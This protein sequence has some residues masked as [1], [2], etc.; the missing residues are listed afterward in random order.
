MPIDTRNI[1]IDDVDKP[2]QTLGPVRPDYRYSEYTERKSNHGK[3]A[4]MAI[5][6]CVI[7]CGICLIVGF[8]RFSVYLV[9][10]NQSS[11]WMDSILL[12]IFKFL[13]VLASSSSLILC[14]LWLAAKVAHASI[15]RM[16]N[17]MPM[18]LIEL[19][20]TRQQ[21]LIRHTL[22]QYYAER[23][24]WA[25]HSDYYGVQTLDLSSSTRAQLPAPFE[26]KEDQPRLEKHQNI[27][28]MLVDKGLIDRSGN[29]ILVGFNDQKPHY[30]EL[31]E[32]GMIALAGMPRTG[33]TS[34]AMQIIAQVLLMHNS[35]VILCDKHGKKA[36]GLVNRLESVKHYLHRCAIDI[37]DIINAIDLWYETG[38]N[39]LAEDSTQQYP[40][41]MIVIDEFTAMI[42]LKVLPPA[43]V[44]KLLSGAVEF[45]KVQCHG[46]I[47]G[48]QWAGH[49]LGG[50]LGTSLRR[51]TTQR[52]I[53]RI[54][55]S[56]AGFLINAAHAKK[57][58]T[59]E[60]GRA[61]YM[62]ASQTT[63]L[64]IVVPYLKPDDLGYL[65]QILKRN[66]LPS[67]P[68]ERKTIDNRTIDDLTMGEKIA[69]ARVLLSRKTSRGY[70]HT[71]DQV[72]AIVG[73]R[74]EKIVEISRSIGRSK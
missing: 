40:V 71:Q 32:T 72:R 62:G 48:H 31:S 52:I 61:L 45:A 17:A 27:L 21:A 6:I 36:D 26:I 8:M 34:T 7:C 57:V 5:I 19:M 55:P 16:P 53:H 2:N 44:A 28:E 67:L 43:S 65:A 42:V 11:V 10:I 4:I 50:T 3:Y 49:L 46:L 35:Q 60:T 70:T 68:S 38:S 39:R 63:P 25:Q 51:A 9:H 30:I 54:D 37:Q 41:C 20:T 1:L 13:V 69:L 22:D 14:V 59:L 66:S 73:I 12:A 29:S 58:S 33:K 15:I 47:I 64:E 18:S 74:N 56:D 24:E 23:K